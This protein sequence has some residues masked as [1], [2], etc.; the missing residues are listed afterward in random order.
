MKVYGRIISRGI[1]EGEVILTKE[2][3]T[4]LGGID[5]R[6]GVIIEKGHELEGQ[7]IAGKILVF[8][9]GKGSTV[10]SYVIYQMKKNRAAPKGIIALYAEQVVAAG[11]IISDLPM[12]DSLEKNPFE[13]L[14]NGMHVAINADKGYVEL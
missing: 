12:L 3:I 11:A 4:F 2:A 6:T 8:P 14:K 7:S 10:G 1:A 13:F 5:P 9:R